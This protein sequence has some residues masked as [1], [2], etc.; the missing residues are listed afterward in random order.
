MSELVRAEGVRKVFHKAGS[1]IDVLHE[2]EFSMTPGE[3]IAIVGASGVGKSTLLHLLGGLDR[4]T[5]GH[6]RFEG[7]EIFAR[8]S[9]RLA[10]FRNESIGFIFQFHYLL[11]EFTAVENVA[12]PLLMRRTEAAKANEEAKVL[13][14]TVGLEHRL[15]HKPNELPGG[16]QQRVA[17]ARA[18]IGKPALILA[19]EPTGNLDVE[20]ARAVGELLFNVVRNEKRSLVV[21]THNPEVAAGA[22]RVLRLKDGKLWEEPRA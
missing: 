4:P 16:E 3:S 15:T 10:S 8:S 17:I 5:S 2:L 6:I 21:A 7:E 18:L 11:P 14:S 20:T 22:D 9:K 1:T 12:M 19:D 13:L